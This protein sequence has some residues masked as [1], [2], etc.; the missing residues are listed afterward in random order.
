MNVTGQHLVQT[1]SQQQQNPTICGTRDA[2]AN[3]ISVRK[4]VFQ[5]RTSFGGRRTEHA[6]Q[7]NVLLKGQ[8]FLVSEC[9]LYG[10]TGASTAKGH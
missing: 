9:L 7:S 6:E 3:V 8:L 2:D 4:C 5:I 10:A 1:V